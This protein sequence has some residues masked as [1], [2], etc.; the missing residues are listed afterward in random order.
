MFHDGKTIKHVAKRLKVL[1]QYLREQG[2]DLAFLLYQTLRGRSRPQT[3]FAKV[4]P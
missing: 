3:Q 1:R 2:A 4:W